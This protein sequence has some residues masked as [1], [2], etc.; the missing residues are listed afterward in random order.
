M[1]ALFKIMPAIIYLIAFHTA[2]HAQQTASDTGRLN[3][4]K[5]EPYWMEVTYNK[6]SHLIFPAAIRYVDLGSEY[7]IA[8]KAEEAPNVLRVK[9]AAAS[10]E[11]ETNFSVITED[12]R[13]YN[14]NVLYNPAPATVNY[15]LLKMEQSLGREHTNEVLFDELGN[16][17][18]SQAELL[19]EN[20]YKKNKSLVKHIGAKSHG[21]RFLLKGIYVSNGKFYFHTELRNKTNVPFQVDFMIFKVVDK[22]VAKRTVV[23]EKPLTPLRVYQ[24]LDKVAGNAVEQSVLLLDQFTISDDKILIIEIFEKNGGRQQSMQV[25]NSD[26]VHAK[27][28]KDSPLKIN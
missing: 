8:G 1:K 7:L 5:V 25:E 18:P 20:I 19:M 9:A 14:F 27:L 16:N 11:G 4:G 2:V 15:D 28:I 23:Q 6:T 21:I 17:P 10:F 3:R 26:L 22:K 24:P 13:F 12:G